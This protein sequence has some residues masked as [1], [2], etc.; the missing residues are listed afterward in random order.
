MREHIL[1][2]RICMS[3]FCFSQWFGTLSGEAAFDKI[4]EVNEQVARIHGKFNSL[5]DARIPDSVMGKAGD[6]SSPIRDRTGLWHNG[7]IPYTISFDLTKREEHIKVL[8]NAMKEWENKTCIRFKKRENDADYVEFYYGDGCN[9]D[10]GRVGGR[11][12]TSLGQGCAD[13][14][15]VVHE[16]GHLVGFWHE[17][18]RPD[19]DEYVE[20]QTNNILRKFRFAFQKY[21]EYKID[22]LGV[23]YDYQS[24]MHYGPKA[25]SRNRRDTIVSKNKTVTKFG[26]NHLSPLDIK[27]ANLLYRCSDRKKVEVR[28]PKFPEDF[29][30]RSDGPSS[31]FDCVQIT[32]PKEGKFWW[33]D[34]YFCVRK[35]TKKIGSS[36][37]PPRCYSWHDLYLDLGTK[38]E[39]KPF[40]E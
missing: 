22:S 37:V 8:K 24:V 29:M 34:N 38:E 25:F 40:L 4:L 3:L 33:D 23:E 32:E 13:H 28:N 5:F 11:Q 21:S 10:V 35:G 19:R 17:Q 12:S 9:S 7:I 14:G 1:L 36:L 31:L 15:I 18:N 26:N 30:W 27:Q 2:W 16:I 6:R 39:T 20:I